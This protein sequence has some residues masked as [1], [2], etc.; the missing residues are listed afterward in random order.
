[1]P[2]AG[3]AMEEGKLISW[4][5]AEGDVV[6]KGEAI[7][8]IE[9]DKV[10][11]EEESPTD[12]VLLK[13]VVGEG[14][15]VPVITT[16][17]FIGNEGEEIPDII[18]PIKKEEPKIEIQNIRVE[19]KL[20][21]VKATAEDF[22]ATPLAKRL[23]KE[24]GVDILSLAGSG[25]AGAV[26]AKDVLSAAKSVTPLARNTAKANN[27]SLSGVTGSGYSG[28]VV[29]EDILKLV[30]AGDSKPIREDKRVPL[31]GMRKVISSRMSQ[32]NLEV[33]AVTLTI[34]ADVT[35]LF[36]I[37]QSINT[38]EGLKVS[39]N[40]FVLRAVTLALEQ[41]P[42]VNS[43]ID[44]DDLVCK[45]DINL[46]F[47]VGIED[48]LLVPVI[49][50]ADNLHLFELSDATKTLA[51]KARNGQAGIDELSGGTFTVTNMGMFNVTNF[52]PIINLPEVAI[53]GVCAIEDKVVLMDGSVKTSKSMNLCLTHDHRLLDGVIS[54]QFLNEIKDLL[55]NP[56]KLLI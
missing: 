12:G 42:I 38:I 2:K 56:A 17:A 41:F 23:A 22:R 27:V 25:V 10:T 36:D 28:K 33:P 55:E 6:K 37:I 45:K 35:A 8:E 49:K 26:L 5:K 19:P 30:G 14:E 48:G 29:N 11:I 16:I 31:S 7:A 3:M 39:I 44:G 21:E 18:A 1:M 46:G 53:L 20:A 54:A 51:N 15:T 50:N 40:D 34:P 52:T 13:I 32:A 9:T 47:A 24:Q 4:L 43:S